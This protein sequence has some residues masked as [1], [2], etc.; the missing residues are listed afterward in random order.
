MEE[1]RIC[2]ICGKNLG[3][4]VCINCGALVCDYCFS[5]KRGLCLNC[6][7]GKII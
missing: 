7:K 5:R 2:V 6:I 3:R 4:Q 1:V